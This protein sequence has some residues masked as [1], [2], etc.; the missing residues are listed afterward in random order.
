MTVIVFM[1]AYTDKPTAPRAALE[2][3]IERLKMQ[4]WA[5]PGD[6]ELRQQIERLEAELAVLNRNGGGA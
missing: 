6:A 4:S 1:N 2:F 3:E 5:D